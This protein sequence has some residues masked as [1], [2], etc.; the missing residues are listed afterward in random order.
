ML[1]LKLPFVD[2][3][4]RRLLQGI[5]MDR[6]WL[7][8]DILKST[9]AEILEAHLQR[10]WIQDDRIKTH[11][12]SQQE[13]EHR[14]KNNSDIIGFNLELWGYN[15]DS[16][17][18][19]LNV[20]NGFRMKIVDHSSD[21]HDYVPI[22]KVNF[23]PKQLLEVPITD[24]KKELLHFLL[25]SKVAG[26]GVISYSDALM[27]KAIEESISTDDIESTCLLIK[28]SKHRAV[29][30]NHFGCAVKSGRSHILQILLDEDSTAFPR[31]NPAFLDWARCEKAKSTFGHILY[32]Y[33]QADGS[34]LPRGRYSF[35]HFKLRLKKYRAESRTELLEK[36]CLRWLSAEEVICQLAG[37][38]GTDP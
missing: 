30:S 19:S 23:I 2:D 32:D 20:Y 25:K 22:I 15:G 29:K 12:S 9:M 1:G 21:R 8:L 36:D 17:A 31:D 18:I 27:Q 3:L 14:W 6:G 37:K 13:L 28:L 38:Y 5:I 7:T 10:S 33:M 11:P 24:S 26:N 16:S 4:D 35:L 34:L